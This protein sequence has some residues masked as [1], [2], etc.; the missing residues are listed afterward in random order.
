[1]FQFTPKLDA[2]LKKPLYVQLYEEIKHEIKTGNLSHHTKLP[3]KRKLAHHL[4][5]SQNTIEAAYDQLVAEGYIKAIPRKGFYVCEMEQPIFNP[6]K[7][8]EPIEEKREDKKFTFDFTHSGVDPR[9]FPYT[10]YRKLASDIWRSERESLLL[11]G[12]P[13][14]EYDLREAI[15]LYIYESRGVRCSPSQIVLG[16]GTPYLIKQLVLLLKNSTWAVEDP[17]YHRK[18]MIFEKGVENTKLI[19]LDRDGIILSEL[20]KSKANVVF[21]TPS[22]QFPCGMIMPISR[23]MQLLHWAEKG[24]NRY[25]IEDDYDSEF[26]YSGKPIPALQGLDSNHKVIYMSTFSKSFLPSLRISYMVLP[27][28]LIQ[29]FQKDFFHAQTVS[30]IDQE[31]LKRFL[32]EGHFEKHIHR[33]RVIYNKKRDLLFSYM[34]T[35][36]PPYIEI[37]G[38]DSGLHVLVRANNGMTENE[39]ICTA[40]QLGVKVYP[41]STYG[42][43]DNQTVLLGFA[44]LS[45]DEIREA[46]QLLAKA[47][48]KR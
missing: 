14:G 34:S 4:Q 25:I 10:T 24:D 18:L 48:F 17:G 39:L 41:V 37:I 38:Q 20:E 45:E 6:K 36:F 32:Q 5:I 46:V 40:A 1:M 11:L 26:R 44:L 29:R 27:K 43:S 47:W 28:P 15:A 33:M 31:I 12:H 30:R 22:H 2:N 19:P 9:S 35:Y 23:R 42:K 16:A 7:S 8:F 21:V 13:Q 3:S